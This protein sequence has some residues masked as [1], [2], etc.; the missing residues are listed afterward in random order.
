MREGQG[1][2]E[3]GEAELLADALAGLGPEVPL[4]VS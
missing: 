2:E 4:V 3:G 1:G